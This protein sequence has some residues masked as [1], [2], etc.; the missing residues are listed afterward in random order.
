MKPPSVVLGGL[1]GPSGA[2]HHLRSPPE[3]SR[4]R[5]HGRGASYSPATALTLEKACRPLVTST[6]HVEGLLGAHLWLPP[7]DRCQGPLLR[8]DPCKALPDGVTS[9]SL[10]GLP[11]LQWF[12]GT[13]KLPLPLQGPLE[14]HAFSGGTSLALEGPMQEKMRAAEDLCVVQQTDKQQVSGLE[15]GEDAVGDAHRG[16]AQESSI[17]EQDLNLSGPDAEAP[18]DGGCER[19]P[20]ISSHLTVM[21]VKAPRDS[22]CVPEKEAQAGEGV[23]Q[24]PRSRNSSPGNNDSIGHKHLQNAEEKA[25]LRVQLR[26]LGPQRPLLSKRRAFRS[27]QTAK[28][29]APAAVPAAAAAAAAA[30]EAAE[31]RGLLQPHSKSSSSSPPCCCCCSARVQV[32][33]C[34]HGGPESF[35]LCMQRARKVDHQGQQ[36]HID[37]HSE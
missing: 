31:R 21:P 14:L 10:S 25:P 4:Q 30:A 36:R 8:E 7:Q 26:P 24:R 11:R 29:A 3:A 2:E 16:G 15:E 5:K 23:K 19:H 17:H 1:E 35:A 34:M 22:R 32:L 13:H 18:N 28:R 9:S 27:R 12:G 37:E 6:G 20:R 33:P